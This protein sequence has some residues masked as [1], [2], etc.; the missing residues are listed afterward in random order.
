MIRWWAWSGSS[1][2]GTGQR[3]IGRVVEHIGVRYI[4]VGIST[5]SLSLV[6]AGRIQGSLALGWELLI[7]CFSG[8]GFT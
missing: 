2:R 7:E 5:N 4:A 1:F 6:D 8:V 3:Y